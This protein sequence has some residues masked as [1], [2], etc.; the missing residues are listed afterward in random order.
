[1]KVLCPECKSEHVSHIDQHSDEFYD[2]Q[3]PLRCL[4]CGYIWE[5]QVWVIQQANIQ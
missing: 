4:K 5:V 2:W 1:M 3:T